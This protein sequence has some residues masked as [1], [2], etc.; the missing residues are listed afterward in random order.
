MHL[1]SNSCIHLQR[2]IYLNQE[3]E[4][5]FMSKSHTQLLTDT[6]K[7]SNMPESVCPCIKQMRIGCLVL[8]NA[9]CDSSSTRPEKL[10]Q[11][12]KEQFEDQLVQKV[13]LDICMTHLHNITK[14]KYYYCRDMEKVICSFWFGLIPN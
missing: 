13:L 9:V 6:S 10:V 11:N 7:I 2:C 3:A 14:S 8:L 1:N 4:N 5:W 12:Q